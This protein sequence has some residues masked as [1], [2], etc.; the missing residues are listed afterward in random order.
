MKKFEVK[1]LETL[2]GVLLDYLPSSIDIIEP[3]H[4]KESAHDING[5]L[6]EISGR[7]HVYDATVKTLKAEK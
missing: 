5:I 1:N 6:N 2:F 3:E 4:L 7:L